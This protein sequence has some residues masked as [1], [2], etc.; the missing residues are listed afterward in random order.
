MH[1]NIILELLG[2][3]NDFFRG[4][5]PLKRMNKRVH[6]KKLYFFEEQILNI[7]SRIPC[8]LPRRQCRVHQAELI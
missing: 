6:E 2:L 4:T 5:Q 3:E 1:V 7:S 8:D